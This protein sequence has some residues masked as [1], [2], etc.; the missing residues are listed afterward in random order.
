[1]AASRWPSKEQSNAEFTGE[2]EVLGSGGVRIARELCNKS[3]CYA[4][5]DGLPMFVPLWIR[6]SY[7]RPVAKQG[8]VES[9]YATAI[10]TLSNHVH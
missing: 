7:W 10:R 2:D 1:M 3:S 5:A 9:V 4:P 6:R 8:E